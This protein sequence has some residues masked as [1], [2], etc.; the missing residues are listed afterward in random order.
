MT[1]VNLSSPMAWRGQSVH[2]HYHVHTASINYHH[3]I[4]V[5]MTSWQ[6]PTSA[7]TDVEPHRATISDLRS[8]KQWCWKETLSECLPPKRIKKVK[9]WPDKNQIKCT[10]FLRFPCALSSKSLQKSIRAKNKKK[11]LKIIKHIEKL[12]QRSQAKVQYVGSCMENPV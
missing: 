12:Y 5:L 10:D 6:T 1:A 2:R 9:E 8:C 11:S 4:L 3:E 7:M